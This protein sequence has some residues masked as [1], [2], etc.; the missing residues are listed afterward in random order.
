M[1]VII[2][3]FVLSAIVT[4]IEYY[5]LL[6]FKI[7]LVGFFVAGIVVVIINAAILFLFNFIFY[8]NDFS[9]ILN[10]FL[11]LVKRKQRKKQASN[12]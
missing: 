3:N 2:P 8:R 5:V 1:K 12:N 9:K 6:S 7:N 11:S 10:R 4:L